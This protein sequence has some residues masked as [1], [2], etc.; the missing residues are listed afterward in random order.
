[1]IAFWSIISWGCI[2]LFY[3]KVIE[4]NDWLSHTGNQKL[5]NLERTVLISIICRKVDISECTIFSGYSQICIIMYSQGRQENFWAPGQKETWPPSSN[6]PNND[7]Q[8]KSTISKESVQQKWIDE[9]WFRKQLSTC[10]FVW[11]L[12]YIDLVHLLIDVFL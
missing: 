4:R 6:S 11:T 8:T 7:T 5:V 2:L 9:L 1:M 10:L 3:R 12:N